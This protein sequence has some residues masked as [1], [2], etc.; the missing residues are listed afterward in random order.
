M[1]EELLS[2]SGATFSQCRTWRYALWRRWD[3]SKS[4]LI[5]IGLNPSTADERQDDPTIRRC[6]NLA[7]REGCGSY[8]MLNLFAFRARD[9]K[10]MKAHAEPIGP[11]NDVAIAA[12]CTFGS[13]NVVAR[14]RCRSMAIGSTASGRS[15]SS[16]PSTPPGIITGTTTRTTGSTGCYARTRAS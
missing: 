5:V 13:S 7:K 4:P 8:V 2:H 15:G 14:T 11:E 16:K 6:I 10:V 12:W 9:P 3:S 1:K